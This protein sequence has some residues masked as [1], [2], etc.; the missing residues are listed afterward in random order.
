MRMKSLAVAGGIA[1]ISILGGAGS[2]IAETKPDFEFRVTTN[3]SDV[4][5]NRA[6]DLCGVIYG[7]GIAR[8]EGCFDSYGDWFLAN[9]LYADGFGVRVDWNT[10][11]GRDGACWDRGGAGSAGNECNENL[12][13]NGSVR[14]QIELW[15]GDT[16]V[17]QTDWS[18]YTPIGQ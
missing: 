15:D 9:D 8:G 11:Y 17:A 5:A 13:E 3:V 1:A 2:A 4:S 12:S 14:L 16:R 6:W 10:D 18:G 7:N